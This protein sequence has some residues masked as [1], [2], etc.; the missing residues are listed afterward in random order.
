MIHV[1]S[2]CIDCR[3]SVD[4]A[5]RTLFSSLELELAP[6]IKSGSLLDKQ[7]YKRAKVAFVI[8]ILVCVREI[9]KW[10]VQRK[11]S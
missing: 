10:A 1:P 5:K 8:R 7:R 6:I 2:I 4:G 9:T 3:V 11:T